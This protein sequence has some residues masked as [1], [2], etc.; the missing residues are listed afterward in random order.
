MGWGTLHR[1]AEFWREVFLTGALWMDTGRPAGPDDTQLKTG[2]TS[3]AMF[4]SSDSS[5][6]G[7][8]WTDPTRTKQAGKYG[9]GDRAPAS[10]PIS[11]FTSR[12]GLRGVCSEKG[13]MFE[14]F[15]ALGG[16]EQPHAPSWPATPTV[17][18]LF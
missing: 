10:K 15:T 4:F 13:P 12:G 17:N 2:G 6:D 7:T 3:N 9:L 18:L 5:P 14:G 1:A 8:E 16:M 11:P